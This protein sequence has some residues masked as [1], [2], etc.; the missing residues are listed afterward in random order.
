MAAERKP[1][2]KR[3][4]Q[5]EQIS[6]KSARIRDE[7]S[8]PLL[9]L[10]QHLLQTYIAVNNAD[11]LERASFLLK[12]AQKHPILASDT[13]IRRLVKLSQSYGTHSQQDVDILIPQG[14]Q[15]NAQRKR[16]DNMMKQKLEEILFSNMKCWLIV[17]DTYETQVNLNRYI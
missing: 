4:S 17:T 6:Q 3:D 13:G 2:R 15:N 8:R 9:K 10:T 12:L 7:K 5:D 11:S 16:A 1:K 14:Q